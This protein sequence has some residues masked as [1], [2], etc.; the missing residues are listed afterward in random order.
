MN[1]KT[2]C[3]EYLLDCLISRSKNQ[4]KDIG[5]AKFLYLLFLTTGFS[6]NKN[7]SGLLDVFNNFIFYPAGFIEKDIQ[8][9]ILHDRFQ[10]YKLTNG[11]YSIK[12]KYLKFDNTDWQTKKQISDAVD[13]L[14][15]KN[16]D[17][18]NMQLFDIVDTIQRWSCWKICRYSAS[19]PNTVIHVPL[20]L[21]QK[22][23]KYFAPEP[24]H[25]YFPF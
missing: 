19:I 4:G 10:K 24:M 2:D 7:E 21:I 16:P 25:G 22:S 6:C 8:N 5:I 23:V 18:I 3:A 14:V 12:N 11:N 20:S 1:S 13:N 9:D 17:I 15:H